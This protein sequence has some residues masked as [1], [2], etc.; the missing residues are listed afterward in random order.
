MIR[1]WWCWTTTVNR[2]IAK[3]Q[4]TTIHR[5]QSTWHTVDAKNGVMLSGGVVS[6]DRATCG[7]VEE[8]GTG[9]RRYANGTHLRLLTR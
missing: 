2:A 1:G 4:T 9:G 7:I 6:V 5:S 8:S 3:I